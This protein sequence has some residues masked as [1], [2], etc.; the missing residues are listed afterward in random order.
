MNDCQVL[1]MREE[2]EKKRD[3]LYVFAAAYARKSLDPSGQEDRETRAS[4][5]M[6]GEGN[7]SDLQNVRVGTVQLGER[8]RERE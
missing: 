3:L 5:V 4:W 6:K 8:E 2:S 7:E 1:E